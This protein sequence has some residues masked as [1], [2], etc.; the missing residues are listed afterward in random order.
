MF[1]QRMPGI[2]RKVFTE[3]IP[4]RCCEF[5]YGNFY[6]GNRNK[7]RI[8]FVPVNRRIFDRHRNRISLFLKHK[9]ETGGFLF[10]MG[11]HRLTQIIF[12]GVL[13]NFLV[14]YFTRFC[15][16]FN[17]SRIVSQ[18]IWSCAPITDFQNIRNFFSA[19]GNGFFQGGQFPIPRHSPEKIGHRSFYERRF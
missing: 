14:F 17:R 10:K 4:F 5:L 7:R 13:G 16:I 12:R 3:T 1:W 15:G 2:Q 9:F 6:L 19:N 8:V 18:T 11:N